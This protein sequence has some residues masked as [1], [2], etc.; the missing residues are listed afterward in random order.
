MVEVSACMLYVPRLFFK[1]LAQFVARFCFLLLQRSAR[2]TV[3]AQLI[4]VLM[5]GLLFLVESQASDV[6]DRP[7]LQGFLSKYMPAR[8]SPA[9][10]KASPLTRQYLF[11]GKKEGGGG[12]GGAFGN[13]AGVMDQ[14]KKAQEIAKKSQELQAE[15]ANQ[16]FEG[17]SADGSVTVSYTHL[18]AHET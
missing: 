12:G 7:A 3:M 8:F 6:A 10:P 15:L 4:R 18:R 14:F 16:E 9:R 13:M 2:S 17:T 11:G 5:T 1:T